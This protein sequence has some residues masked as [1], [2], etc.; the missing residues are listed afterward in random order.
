MPKEKPTRFAL[1]DQHVEEDKL[2]KGIIFYLKK[3]CDRPN[4]T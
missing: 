1:D 2:S 4:L 3:G